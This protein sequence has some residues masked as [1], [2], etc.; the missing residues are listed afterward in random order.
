M[1]QE[2]RDAIALVTQLLERLGD[3][4]VRELEVRQGDLRVKVTKADPA[5][6]AAAATSAVP[7]PERTS[8]PAPAAAKAA[9]N[10]VTAPLTG[11]FYRAPSAQASPFVQPGSVIAAGDVIGLI[12]A[13]K[14]FN[15]VRTSVA[16][17]VRRVVAE[18]GQ[19]VRAHQPLI[20]LE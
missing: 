20:E 10:V 19:L 15:E 9:A 11:V 2:A 7:E 1:A 13:M 6:E 8:R 12:E 5:P 18:S 3:G 4:A 16:G 17:R 14:L